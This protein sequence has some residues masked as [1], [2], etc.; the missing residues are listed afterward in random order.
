MNWEQM[1]KNVGCR[2]QL[3][4]MACRLDQNGRELPP[5]DDDWIIDEASSSGVRISNIRT[6]HAT[7]SGLDCF[8]ALLSAAV[9]SM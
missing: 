8:K 5:I 7:T 4:P 3:V 9:A 2:V 6:G 1:K